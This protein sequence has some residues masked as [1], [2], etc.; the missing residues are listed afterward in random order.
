M[1]KMRNESETRA[2]L[3]D[4]HLQQ[5]GW[6]IV[7]ESRIRR[8]YPITKGRLIGSGKQCHRGG[9]NDESTWRAILEYFEPATQLG[10]TATP[11]RDVN[12]DTYKYFG[13]PVSVYSLKEGINDGFL[14]PFRVKQI[15][16]NIDEY[17]FT[18]D[19]DVISVMVEEG[20]EY[21]E[22]DFNRIITIKAR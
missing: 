7:P 5:Q 2:E 9:A 6:A 13:E 22:S 16:T 12:G 21:T 19:D 3:I 8:E 20:K 17:Q 1:T 14:T 15:Q 11:K 18:S 10:L 4:P